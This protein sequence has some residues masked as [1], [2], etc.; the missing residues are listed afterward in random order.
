MSKAPAS[1]VGIDLGCSTLKA[2]RLQKKGVQYALVRIA[3]LPNKRDPASQALPLEGD[4]AGQIKELSSAVKASGADVHYSINALNST[5]RYVELP[6]IQPDELRNNLK[7]NSTTYL[8]QSFDNYTF[9]ACALDAEALAAA[10]AKKAAKKGASTVI[11]GKLKM[12][13]GGMSTPELSLYF[14]ASRKAGIKPHSLQLASVS[15]INAFEAAYPDIFKT[16]A[17]TLLDIGFL[18]SSLTILDRGK[19]LLTRAVPLGGRQITDYLAQINGIDYAKAEIG[20]LKGELNIGEAI[21]RTCVT[22][23]REVHSS[24]NFFEKNSDLPIS[25]VYLSGA[26]TSS[27]AVVDALSKDVGRACEAL[28][29][30]AGLAVELPADQQAVFAASQAG[31]ATAL[32]AARSY[33]TIEAVVEKAAPAPKEK[34]TAIQK[35]AA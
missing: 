27:Q 23:I 18:S 33:A 25:K 35:P 28:D 5:V 16:Q 30:T 29:A 1:V 32:G 20:K 11:H 8:R 12:L 13:V 26:S 10:S 15:L 14:H 17:V 9:D 24:I 19:P 6:N 3:T 21:A 34:P 31:F 4:V 22:L 2:V 7:L